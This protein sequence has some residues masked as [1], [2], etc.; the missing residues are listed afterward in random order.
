MPARLTHIDRLLLDR[1]QA[2]IERSVMR[3]VGVMS[4]PHKGT[5][6]RELGEASVEVVRGLDQKKLE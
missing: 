4:C 6:P 2:H 1:R 5:S 3:F